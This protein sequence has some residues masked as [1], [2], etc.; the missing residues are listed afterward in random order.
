MWKHLLVPYDFS[1][2]ADRALELALDLAHAE[3]LEAEGRPTTITL[4]HVCPLPPNLSRATLVTP[5]EQDGLRGRVTIEQLT[6]GAAR[7]KLAVLADQYR[8]A[9]GVAVTAHAVAIEGDA[10]ANELVRFA[11]MTSAD[12]IVIGTHGR[13]GLSHLLLGSVAEK[14][15]REACCPV[16]TVREPTEEKRAEVED[17]RGEDE[18]AG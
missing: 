2:C 1:R 10:I 5:D 18:A 9:F 11:R 17:Q 7:E 6:T 13:S 14:V 8:A 3:S 12:V 16:V 15:I 4:L